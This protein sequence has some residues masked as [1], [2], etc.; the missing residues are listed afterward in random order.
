VV[1]G[2]FV[3]KHER[4]ITLAGCWA[5]VRRNFYEAREQAP[6]RCAWILRQIGHL[7]RIE[8]TRRR[9]Q[10]GPSKRVAV[11]MGQSRPICERLHR[12]LEQFS[13]IISEK[14]T[15]RRRFRGRS[16]RRSER[17]KDAG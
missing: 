10:L 11:R 7:Y 17:D 3:K 15:E 16:S 4:N 9:G 14:R 8:D 1:Y 13:Q 6:Q 5:H 12:A 2:S